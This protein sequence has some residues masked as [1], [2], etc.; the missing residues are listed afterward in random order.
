[1]AD[2][3][4]RAALG[5]F[6]K[7][8][9]DLLFGG[10]VEGAGGLI[11]HQYLGRAHEGAGQSDLLPFTDAQFY[12]ILEQAAQ[13]GVIALFEGA[14][15][16]CGTGAFRRPG[17]AGHMR[18]PADISKPDV[19]PD[20]HIVVHIIL[21][22]DSNLSAPAG[23]AQ[24]LQVDAIDGYPALFG[25]IETAEELD[26][27]GLARAVLAHQGY[28]LARRDQEGYVVQSILILTGVLEAEALEGDAMLYLSW[29]REGICGILDIGL[30]IQE[31]VEVAEEEV[32]FIETGQAFQ[33]IL[34]EVLA[35]L[36]GTEVH[37]QAAYGDYTQESLVGYEQ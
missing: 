19:V 6:A 4:G 3:D 34:Q 24:A 2:Y 22:D 1:M 16:A 5:Q 8:S 29:N 33:H 25:I 7:L 37:D 23:Q 17:D 15:E 36:E 10:G 21:Q 27:R 12:A 9:E 32:T 20:G 18:G 35:L 13:L 26:E 14:D 11:K 31:L 30:Q 28:R